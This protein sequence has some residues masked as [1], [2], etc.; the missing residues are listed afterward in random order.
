MCVRTYH[1][2]RCMLASFSGSFGG[3]MVGR[4]CVWRLLGTSDQSEYHWPSLVI[5]YRD[6]N[7]LSVQSNQNHPQSGHRPAKFWLT[8]CSHDLNTVFLYGMLLRR[9]T[10]WNDRHKLNVPVPSRK[11]RQASTSALADQLSCQPAPVLLATGM[12]KT[13][14]LGRK[15]MV[16]FRCNFYIL[17]SDTYSSSKVK[18]ILLSAID[19]GY[20]S[21]KEVLQLLVFAIW[22]MLQYNRQPWHKEK[23][24]SLP[25]QSLAVWYHNRNVLCGHSDTC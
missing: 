4:I 16:I 7:S 1:L 14:Q 9:L 15:R 20:F 25:W 22:L 8:K 12:G 6:N 21:M 17:Y 18:E 24:D 2:S 3:N 10:C 5:N 11:W 13:L 23:W 19:L